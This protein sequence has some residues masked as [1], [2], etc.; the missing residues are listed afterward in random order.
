[1]AQ[2]SQALPLH[3]PNFVA[4]ALPFGEYISAQLLQFHT[5]AAVMQHSAGMHI[6]YSVFL[7][8]F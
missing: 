8:I 3:H 4:E 2:R 6:V 5:A 7:V 1:M